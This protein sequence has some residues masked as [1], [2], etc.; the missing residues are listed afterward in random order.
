[1]TFASS[2]CGDEGFDATGFVAAANERGAGLELGPELMTTEEGKRVHELS[3]EEPAGEAP[4]TDPDGHGG[5]S[6]IVTESDDA[7]LAEYERCEQTGLLICFRVANIAIALE[8]DAEPEQLARLRRA[9][10]ALEG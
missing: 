2:G 10:A 6:L 4:A 5:G 8:P 9:I 3:L 1:M 7:A